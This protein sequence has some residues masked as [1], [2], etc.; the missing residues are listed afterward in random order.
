MLRSIWAPL[1]FWTTFAAQA[2]ICCLH[3]RRSTTLQLLPMPTF[4]TFNDSERST[5]GA[6]ANNS[7][8]QP[9]LFPCSTTLKG[10]YL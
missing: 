8:I 10:R 3:F 5:F 6:H 7:G 4:S 2:D 1:S 9:H